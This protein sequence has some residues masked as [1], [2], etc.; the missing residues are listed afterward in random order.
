MDD[1]GTACN[2]HTT[3]VVPR[4]IFDSDDD[5]FRHLI[6]H[7]LTLSSCDVSLRRPFTDFATEY[8]HRPPS[9]TATD[10]SDLSSLP[11]RASELPAGMLDKK[12]AEIFPEFTRWW[13]RLSGHH[14]H[15][16]LSR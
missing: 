1:G 5:Y 8:S 13:G 12:A 6:D 4:T 11:T 3:K 2:N 16:I 10:L 7:G 15:H 14:H 9:L